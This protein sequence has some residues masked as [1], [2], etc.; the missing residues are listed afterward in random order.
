MAEK[1]RFIAYSGLRSLFFAILL[2]VAS[3]RA[4]AQT[5]T[6]LYNFCSVGATCSDGAIPLAP[7][8]RD[9]AGNFYGTTNSAGSRFGS[10]GNVFELSPNGNGGWTATTL[11]AFTMGPDGALPELSS[12]I[13]DS[14]GNLYG[15]AQSGGIGYGVVFELSPVG[16]TWN[17]TVL[18][19]FTG[20]GDGAHPWAGVI[21]D[22][23]GNLYGSTANGGP[24]NFGTVF[25]LSPFAGG[26]TEQV[27]YSFSSS[28]NFEPSGLTMDASRNI[29]GAAGLTVFELSSNGAGGWN[30]T[31]LH[32]FAGQGIGLVGTPVIDNGGN[33]FGTLM[34]ETPIKGKKLFGLVYKLSQKNGEWKMQTLEGWSKGTGP[35]GGVVLDAAG[36]IYGTTIGGTNGHGSIFELV[37]VPGKAYQK[38]V[39]W[40]FSGTDGDVPFSSLILDNAGN[41]YGTTANG[42]SKGF[43]TIFQVTP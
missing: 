4:Q 3:R 5:E 31:T 16:S 10:N 2:V 22:S 39:L 18:C 37:A 12:L 15:T 26:W 43:G 32:N 9:A 40:N 17:E 7:L 27:I 19:T 41:I 28:S 20:G 14:S 24:G 13:F 6:V 23:A 21:M 8:I 30:A 29:F 34:Q 33:V 38:K 11:H 25:E 1:N 35:V 36:N 42:G